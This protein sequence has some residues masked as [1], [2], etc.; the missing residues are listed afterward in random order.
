[1]FLGRTTSLES[2]RAGYS[3]I[4]N[5]FEEPLW[6]LLGLVALL[7]VVASASAADLL[8]ARGAVRRREFAVR[9]AMV[10]GRRR[11]IRQMLT[12]ALVWTVLGAGAGVFVAWW[13]SATLVSLMTTADE[14]IILEVSPHWRVSAFCLLLAFLTTAICATF[15]AFRATRLDAGATLEG[16]S[17]R[18]WFWHPTFGRWANP[19]LP[20]R[21]PSRSSCC[22]GP[23]SSLAVSRAS[24][25]RT[26]ASNVMPCS[27]SRLMPVHQVI[28][29][30]GTPRSMRDCSNA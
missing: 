9:L 1:M 2:A 7:L 14:P 10:G 27:S 30:A 25:T 12:E 6:I 5:Q 13:G 11:L 29:A 17:R 28:R 8:L 3:H 23:R 18:T 26:W 19:S 22:S 15:P 16:R 20:R 24:S 4:R 21:S